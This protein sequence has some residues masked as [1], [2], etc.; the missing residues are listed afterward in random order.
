MIGAHEARP[1]MVDHRGLEQQPVVDSS[2]GGAHVGERNAAGRRG[3]F[4]LVRVGH[5]VL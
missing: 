2:N 3:Y 4:L 1:V 5:F